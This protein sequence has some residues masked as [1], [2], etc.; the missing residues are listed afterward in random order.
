MAAES[1]IAAD[2]DGNGVIEALDA[3]LIARYAVGF[4]DGP[5]SR[6]GQ[7]SFDPSNRTYTNVT[8]EME[9]QNYHGFVI[10]DVSLNW[11]GGSGPGKPHSMLILPD[12]ITIGEET[13]ILELAVRIGPNSGLRS[14]D[15][16]L[17]YDASNLRFEEAAA[18]EAAAGRQFLV[19]SPREGC[20]NAALYGANPVTEAGRLMVFR[21]KP[22]G[23]RFAPTSVEF[24]RMAVDERIVAGGITRV[25]IDGPGGSAS[26]G[27]NLLRNSPNPFNPGTAIR[28]DLESREFVRLEVCNALGRTVAVLVD[29]NLEA[30]RH[31]EN[32]DGRD[33]RGVE[34]PSGVYVS[35]LTV[36]GK[37]RSIKMIKIR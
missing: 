15:I 5:P 10:G 28:F 20:I 23:T 31:V 36:N 17:E 11:G 13:R 16:R 35:R 7:W 1:R 2:A 21:F 3:A 22:A 30:G 14:M 19:H 18:C 25:G 26:R 32:W 4:S 34:A 24:A 37:V 29:R 12:T 27:F 6:A 8:R 9:G 33:D